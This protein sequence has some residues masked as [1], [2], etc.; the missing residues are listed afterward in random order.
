MHAQRRFEVLAERTDLHV[1]HMRYFGKGFIKK[2]QMSP[3][4]FVQVELLKS[5]N[6]ALREP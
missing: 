3:D 6:S 4:A 2:C 5:L 1:M